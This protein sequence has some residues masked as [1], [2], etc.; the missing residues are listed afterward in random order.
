MKDNE[1]KRSYLIEVKG[2]VQGV[3][4][5]PFIYRLA[6]GRGIYGSV[7]NTTEGVLIN[8]GSIS[9]EDLCGLITSIRKEK[10]PAST[11][12]EITWKVT[13]P[14]DHKGFTIE[15][16][17][18]TGSR[19]Q[20]ISPDL[21]TCGKCLED[22]L[23]KDDRRRYLY[24]FT[25]CTSCGP[26]FTIIKNMPYDRPGTTM[27]GFTMCPDCL[28][29]YNDPHDRRFHAQPNACSKCGPL[30][31]LVDGKGRVIEEGL[32]IK[33]AAALLLD[34]YLIGLKSLGGFQIACDAS[35]DQAV[36]LLRSRKNR[37]SKPFAVMSADLDWIK[38]Y[39]RLSPGELSSLKSPC[40]PI[41]LLRKKEGIYPLSAMV[42]PGNR[43]DGIMLPYTPLHHIL[44]HYIKIPLVMTSGNISEE[45]IASENDEARDRLKNI[46]DY[47][48]VHNRDI[49]SRYDDSVIRVF[50]DREMVLRRA[51]GYAPYPVKIKHHTGGNN[52]LAVGAHE[53][54]TFTILTRKYAIT[55]QH[56]GDLDTAQS[57]DFFTATLDNYKALFG[58]EDF[59]V[60]AHDLHPDYR[61]TRAA[62]KMAP[63]KDRLFAV[64]HHKAHIA[65]VLAEHGLDGD[66]L[67][68]SWDGSG[69]GDDG[70]I[71]GSEIFMVDRDLDFN[72]IG[73]LTE[74]FLPGGDASIRRPYRM[75]AAYLYMLFKGT[76]GDDPALPRYICKN[77]SYPDKN[78]DEIDILCRQM[79]TGLNSPVTTSMG[80]FF[81]AVSSLTGCAHIN[82]YEGEAAVS[83]EM[84]MDQDF[85]DCLMKS[86]I[87]SVSPDKRYDISIKRTGGMSI[88]DDI[89]IFSQVLKDH[90]SR[91]EPG[92][93]SFKFHNTLAQI[94]LDISLACRT[95]WRIEKIALSGGVF[96]N[97]YLLDLCYALLENNGFKV[98]SNYKVPV[99]DGG[100][101][102]GQAY[103]AAFNKVFI[104]KGES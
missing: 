50:R 69:Y 63:G 61:S 2:I 75:A 3:G 5:R 68:F 81:D 15:K 49:Y 35:S 43:Y 83:L 36:A 24:P 39:Y 10:P 82:T 14:Q 95:S 55:S 92:L 27:A 53:K 57:M 23:N 91:L 98:Y 62:E 1:K 37:P 85:I 58:I 56:I 94:I 89:H 45:P 16:S 26:R 6:R 21:A 25:N 30:L 93:I 11:I 70:N 28:K 44:F 17:R 99:N 9:E 104:N 54:N 32:P 65:G 64:Q 51:R 8:T 34:G 33:S 60:I 4:F 41:V 22:I 101:S 102:L 103:T 12:E 71:W 76:K 46:C 31:S 52:I 48:L 80:R 77:I 96:Q 90:G 38:R 100:I 67:G 97:N 18:H 29:E 73:H 47:Y 40:A 20:L 19:F 74:K 79:K 66:V 59:H 86:G 13:E 42:S 88:I 7:T 87:R 84:A 78:Q 72:R